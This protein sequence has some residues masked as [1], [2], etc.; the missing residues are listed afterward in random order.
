M[1]RI[2][3][4]EESFA[5][6]I[7]VKLG[8]DINKIWNFKKNTVNPYKIYKCCGKKVWLYCL[9]K[10]YHNDK[11]G[12]EI[13]CNHFYNGKRCGYCGGKKFIK[14]IVLHNGE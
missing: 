2:P 3:K 6:Y 7:E 1:S 9:E 5:Y 13:T 10:D 14:K 12:Y 11:G 8:L 4:Y